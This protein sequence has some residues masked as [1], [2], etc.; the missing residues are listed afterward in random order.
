VRNELTVGPDGAPR[1]TPTK[2]IETIDTQ[3][4]LRSIGNR[5]TPLRGLPFDERRGIIPNDDFRVLD[6]N[7]APLPGTYTTGWIQRGPSGF[8]GTNKMCA[9]DTV[10][11]VFD[12]ALSG[13]LSRPICDRRSL[14]RLLEQRRPDRID[15]HGWSAIDRHERSAGAA[16]GRP[17]VKVVDIA[18]MLHIASETP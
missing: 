12:D 9:A 2:D 7:D 16:T 18:T 14:Q 4:V 1:A 5:G 3:L 11:R 17:R 15:Q 13:R 8:I 6:D 10:T